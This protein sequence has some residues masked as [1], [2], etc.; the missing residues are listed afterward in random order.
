MLETA[1]W[2]SGKTADGAFAGDS[3]IPQGPGLR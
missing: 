3:A 2:E 1:V